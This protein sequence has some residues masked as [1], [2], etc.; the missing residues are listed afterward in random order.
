MC[1]HLST[2]SNL[3]GQTLNPW[4]LHLSPGGSSGGEAA[5]VAAGGSVLGIGTD[6]GGSVRQPAAVT[7]LYGIRCTVG[8]IGIGGTRSTMLGNEGIIGTAGPLCRSK[9][10]LA[11]VTEILIRRTIESDPFLTPPLPWKDMPAAVSGRRL[12]VGVLLDDGVVQPITP[13]RRALETAVDKLS[14]VESI[15]IV[16]CEPGNY[17]RRGWELAREL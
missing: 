9:R 11:L 12:R 1:Y 7:G 6:I 4:N 14:S 3:H 16:H 10:D 8:R 17:Y 2:C 13:I 15:E 5:S